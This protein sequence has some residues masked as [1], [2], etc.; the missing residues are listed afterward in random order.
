MKATV[1]ICALHIQP[2]IAISRVGFSSLLEV[3]TNIAQNVEGKLDIGKILPHPITV[4]WNVD[5]YAGKVQTYLAK[6]MKCIMDELVNV[7]FTTDM[8]TKY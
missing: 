3:C 7:S 1:Q 5:I 6:E 4:S 8:T 2:F